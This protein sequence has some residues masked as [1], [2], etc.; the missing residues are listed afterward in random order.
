MY[1]DKEG[2]KY[3]KGIYLKYYPLPLEILKIYKMYA[4]FYASRD[5][6]LYKRKKK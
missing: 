6:L 4:R 1:S 2:W 3:W 5:K